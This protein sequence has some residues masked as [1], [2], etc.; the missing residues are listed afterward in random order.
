MQSARPGDYPSD[1]SIRL[2][3]VAVRELLE[4][5][6]DGIRSY[7]YNYKNDVSRVYKTLGVICFKLFA[8]VAIN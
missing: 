5:C 7:S 4:G 2:L 6:N 3:G 1:M 8:H